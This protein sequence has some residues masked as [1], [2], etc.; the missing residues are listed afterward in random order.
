[1]I[2]NQFNDLLHHCRDARERSEV[3]EKLDKLNQWATGSGYSMWGRG[4]GTDELKRQVARREREAEA[5]GVTL[6]TEP[7]H[8]G[9]PSLPDVNVSQAPVDLRRITQLNFTT[10]DTSNP[11]PPNAP[12]TASA[13]P[14]RPKGKK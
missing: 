5:A 6:P 3:L 14:K 13:K 4:V 11:T 1:L 7:S 2:W 9:P 8:S 10:V 12:P